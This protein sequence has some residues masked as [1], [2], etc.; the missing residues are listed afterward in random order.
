MANNVMFSTVNVNKLLNWYYLNIYII[1][2]IAGDE[3]KIGRH[4]R[5]LFLVI[6]AFFNVTKQIITYQE[7]IYKISNIISFLGIIA[8]QYR[9]NLTNL[10]RWNCLKWSQEILSKNVIF[11]SK[12]YII[13]G[14]FAYLFLIYKYISIL[15]K[16][17][18]I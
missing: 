1:N 14:T 8:S 6:K 10:C 5:F 17:W 7:E 18:T 12:N 15:L 16:I 4:P 3:I 13:F 9:S 11:K 2:I